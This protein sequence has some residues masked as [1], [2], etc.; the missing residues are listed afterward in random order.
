MTKEK[1]DFPDQRESNLT[2]ESIVNKVFGSREMFCVFCH[3]RVLV[4]DDGY[5]M[6]V[7]GVT[8]HNCKGEY[9]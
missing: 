5:T 8:H 3:M 2:I 1:E 4:T 6:D 7:D 9:L